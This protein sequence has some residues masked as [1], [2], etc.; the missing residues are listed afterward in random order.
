MA[1]GPA[2]GRSRSKSKSK[3]T[4]PRVDGARQ[5]ARAWHSSDEDEISRQC[6]QSPPPMGMDII[7]SSLSARRKRG[8]KRNKAG[9]YILTPTPAV[10]S[11]SSTEYSSGASPVRHP[12][13]LNPLPSVSTA[14]HLGTS[15]LLTY[16][17]PSWLLTL[18]QNSPKQLLICF[19]L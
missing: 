12:T 15:H 1:D 2:A 19:C 3:S 17:T 10:D 7:V 14:G 5:R 11:D 4:F 6:S 9:T 18:A 13:S 8:E 16:T